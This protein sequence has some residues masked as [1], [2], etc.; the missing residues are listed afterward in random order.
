M[1]QKR[2]QPQTKKCA[3]GFSL[4][5]VIITASILGVLGSVAYPTYNNANDSAK[6][7]EAKANILSIPPIIGAYI[8]ATGEAPKTWDDLKTITAIMTNNGPA[9]GDLTSPIT[10]PSSIYSLSI[11][12][13]AESVYTLTA[14]HVVNRDEEE[15]NEEEYQFAI[16]SCF[17]I[18][19]GASELKT[20]NLNDIEEKLNCG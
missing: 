3:S 16:K 15:P 4:P 5:E 9:T 19:N 1:L 14:T 20:G 10:L 18:S 8:D 6:L 7:A 11:E 12:G 2:K 17:N 13:P